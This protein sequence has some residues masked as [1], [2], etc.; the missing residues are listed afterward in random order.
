MILE[1]VFLIGLLTGM[2]A[3]GIL[4]YLIYWDDFQAVKEFNKRQDQY[5]RMI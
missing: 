5:R 2:I 1:L 4:F 3:G